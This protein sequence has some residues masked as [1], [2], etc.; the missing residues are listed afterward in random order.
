MVQRLRSEYRPG[1]T[2]GI[3]CI[4]GLFGSIPIRTCTINLLRPKRNM[5]QASVYL[6]HFSGIGIEESFH[7]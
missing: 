3:A 1:N 5:V 2:E 4:Y 7:F 6:H